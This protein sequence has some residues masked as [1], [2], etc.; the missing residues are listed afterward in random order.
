MDCPQCRRECGQNDKVCSECGY[1]LCSANTPLTG[2]NRHTH[3]KRRSHTD[4]RLLRCCRA[5]ICCQC[6]AQDEE[7]GIKGAED[8]TKETEDS[9]E[10][11]SVSKDE[12]VS[13]DSD[14]QE[15]PEHPISESQAHSDNHTHNDNQT[16]PRGQSHTHSDDHTHSKS[17][18][19]PDTGSPEDEA[20]ET[21]DSKESVRVSKGETISKVSHAM[22][23]PR[24]TSGAS[25]QGEDLA[26]PP[27]TVLRSSQ[28]V[29]ITAQHGGHAV[30]P[31]FDRCKVLRDFIVNINSPDVKD[32]DQQE[33]HPI[34]KSHTH[35]DNHTHCCDHTHSQSQGQSDTGLPKAETEETL[36]EQ[37]EKDKSQTSLLKSENQ[38]RDTT[39]AEHITPD[40][41]APGSNRHTHSKRR[42]HADNRLLR[43]C[44]AFICCQCTAQDEEERSLL[45]SENEQTDTTPAEHIPPGTPATDSEYQEETTDNRSSLGPEPAPEDPSSCLA[46]SQPSSAD[47]AKSDAKS[48]LADTDDMDGTLSKH[49]K[50]TVCTAHEE[51]EETLKEQKEKYESQ[52]SLLESENQQRD[53]TPAEH[54]TPG[55]PA[56]GSNRHTHS[57][58]RSHTDNHLLRCCRAFICCQCTAQDEEEGIKGAEDKTK[59]TEDSKESVSVTKDET[60]STDSDQQEGPEHPISES[61]V[62]SDN[63]THNDNQTHSKSQSHSHSD[64][65]THSKS[66]GHPDAG[67]PEDEAEETEDSKESVSMSKGETISK[68]SHAM[69]SPR[70]TSG[71]SLPGGDLADHPHTVLRSSK[72]ISIT[73]QHGSHAVAPQFEGCYVMG[74]FTVN[75]HKGPDVKDCDQQKGHPISK[76][77]THS[78]NHT[79][80]GDHTHSKSQ[81]QS[82]TGLPKAETEETLKEQKEKD[83]SQT[84][85]LKSENQQRDTTPAEHITPDTPAPDSKYQEETTDNRSSLGPEPAPEDPSSCLAQSQP[86]SADP[87]K[88]DAKSGLADTDDVDGTL[89]KDTKDTVC[90]TKQVKKETLKEQKEKDKSQTSLLKSENQQRDTTPAE[91]ITPDTPAPGTKELVLK[92]FKKIISVVI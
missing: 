29:S 7:E 38:Q 22:S 67:S 56:P 8:K 46:Q 18:G 39:P 31:H 61:Q 9:K 3:S 71:A 26:D 27:H 28:S 6:T 53:T 36:K 65:H 68:V 33:R 77:H 69:P 86:S 43:C 25:L 24:R 92:S 16:H 19:H 42:S 55:T 49:T 12:T 87:A 34:S 30:A 21:E 5:F 52:T 40:T 83:K 72:S 58:R 79:H 37:K 63:H 76:S 51:M 1:K 17:L 62:Y 82:D 2:S 11:V 48:G 73:A 35:S 41:P 74:D 91:H 10:S 50:H 20:E 89:S 80:C 57:K 47:P 54:L 90:T 15:G 70:R 78:D 13:T 85:L 59:E 23:S 88:S 66:L 84:S 64:D 4:N 44:R 60:V 14:Q 75:I 81:G 45:E 32:C